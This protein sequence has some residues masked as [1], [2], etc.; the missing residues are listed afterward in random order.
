MKGVGWRW[1]RPWIY[2][3]EPGL[4]PTIGYR[5]PFK[6]KLQLTLPGRPRRSTEA[7]WGTTSCCGGRCDACVCRW[8]R[9]KGRRGS[10]ASYSRGTRTQNGV[11]F[12]RGKVRP[13]PVRHRFGIPPV[14]DGCSGTRHR[15]NAPR[16]MLTDREMRG[17][18]HR[19][20]PPAISVPLTRHRHVSTIPL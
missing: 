4:P 5:V 12:H 11:S 14:L 8:M 16:S 9:A 7:F 18:Y 17:S 3:A 1:D 10:R 2:D 15:E 13:Y 6:T 20:N 19:R